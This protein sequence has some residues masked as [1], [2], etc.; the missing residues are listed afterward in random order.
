VKGGL[1]LGRGF[2]QFFFSKT[3]FF[4]VLVEKTLILLLKNGSDKKT[5][6]NLTKTI[7]ML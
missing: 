2:S 4:A 1:G 7:Q 5:R 3:N 6:D